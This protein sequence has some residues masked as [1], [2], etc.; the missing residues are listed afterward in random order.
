LLCKAKGILE[1]KNKL[2]LFSLARCF[3]KK[4]TRYFLTKKACFVRQRKRTLFYLKIFSLIKE[5]IQFTF[6]ALQRVMQFVY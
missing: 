4:Y 3:A 5:K 2:G 1:N 6:I